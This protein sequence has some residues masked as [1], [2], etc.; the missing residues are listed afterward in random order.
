MYR[1]SVVVF[2]FHYSVIYN[3]GGCISARTTDYASRWLKFADKRSSALKAYLLSP[4]LYGHAHQS[5]R[6][7]MCFMCPRANL[8]DILGLTYYPYIC[9]YIYT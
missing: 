3:S 7:K 2:V 4:F 8:Y 1:I 5:D 9:V 6:V